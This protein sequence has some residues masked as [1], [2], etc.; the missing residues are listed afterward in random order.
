MFM[1][2]DDDVDIGVVVKI[3]VKIKC[4]FLYKVLLFNDDYM[5]MEFVV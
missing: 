1:N 5:L 2:S 4:L 3:C